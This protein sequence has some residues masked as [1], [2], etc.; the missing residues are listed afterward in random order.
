MA[1]RLAWVYIRTRQQPQI[2]LHTTDFQDLRFGAWML[3]GLGK[4]NS[5][6][7]QHREMTTGIRRLYFVRTSGLG[8]YTHLAAAQNFSTCHQFLLRLSGSAP[9]CSTFL[10]PRTWPEKVEKFF[11]QAQGDIKNWKSVFCLD[12]WPE[13]IYAMD[14]PAFQAPSVEAR[15][16]AQTTSA[17]FLGE[18]F[19]SALPW[20]S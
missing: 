3:P 15:I 5:H 8:I 14:F 9:G 18:K 13:Y 12:I 19:S 2:S 10:R 4:K 20:C 6:R 11:S 7:N 1:R 16:S 17:A